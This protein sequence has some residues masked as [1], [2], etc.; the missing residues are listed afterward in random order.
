MSME[1][2]HFAVG[3]GSAFIVLNVLPPRVRRKI[4]DYGFIGI[5][6]GLWAMV[7]DLAR[8]LPGMVDFH[9]SLFANIFFLH[10]IMDRLD[11]NDSVWISGGLIGVM[12]LLMVPLWASDYWHR[13]EK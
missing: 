3:A 1:I 4:P 12:V 11:N 13:R 8:F 9:K 6:A 2:G 10:Q 5:I 7:P